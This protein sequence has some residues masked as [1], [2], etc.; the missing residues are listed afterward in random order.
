MSLDHKNIIGALQEDV[1]IPSIVEEKAQAAFRRIKQE[2][3]EPKEN[4]GSRTAKVQ[5]RKP[6]RKKTAF[7]VAA[8]VLVLGTVTVGATAYIKWSRGFSEGLQATPEQQAKLEEENMATLLGQ[9]SEDQGIKIT[10]VQCITDNYFAHLAFKVEGYELEQGS[11]PCFENINVTV[12]G[13][14]PLQN[15]N[16]SQS[17]D[18]SAGFYDGC[19][20]GLDGQAVYADGSPLE[21]DEEGT[22]KIDYTMEDGSMEYQITLSNT[23]NKGY[24]LD[25]AVRIELENLGTVAKAEYIPDIQGTW[26]FEFNL[27]GSPQNREFKLNEPLGDTKATVVSGEISPISLQAELVFPREEQEETSID[28]NGQEQTY[29][30]Y[31]E[32]PSLFGVRLKDGQLLSLFRGPGSMGYLSED[33]DRYQT[34]FAID[35]IIDVEQVD[36]LLFVKSYAEEGT[37]ITEDNFYVVPVE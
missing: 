33:S 24:L 19:I 23:Y 12:D 32:P 3:E 2:A 22:L 15:E 4:A 6:S 27:G 5:R 31:R 35:R 9:T 29:T 26:S 16:P 18:W 7:L 13:V 34:I 11:E 1:V 20:M 8:A 14:D 37:Q 28:E 30:T 36:A 17:V 25:K 10:A 21:T